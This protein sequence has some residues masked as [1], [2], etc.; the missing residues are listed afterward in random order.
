MKVGY[1]RISTPTQDL[2]MQIRALEKEGCRPIYHEQISGAKSERLQL[3]A[4]LEFLKEG[5]TLY[6]WSIDRLGRTQKEL[7]NIISTLKERGIGFKSI[8]QNIDTSTATGQMM[9]GMFSMMAEFER[10]MGIERTRAGLIAARAR[11][12]LGGRKFKVDIRERLL[13]REM[14]HSKR[15]TLKEI[16]EMN[17]ISVATIYNYLG[18]NKQEPKDA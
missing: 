6:V 11:G 10:N 9:F 8:Q 13:I 4:C 1:A 17:K 15:Y 16:C 12:K 3:K 2:Q 14:Y 18:E 7:I 5:D